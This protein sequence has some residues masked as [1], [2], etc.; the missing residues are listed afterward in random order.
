[1]IPYVLAVA[2]WLFIFG[3]A[4]CWMVAAGRADRWSERELNEQRMRRRLDRRR[5]RE[6]SPIRGG[7]GWRG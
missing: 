2:A 1:M 3:V 4:W 5:D 6:N 7:G